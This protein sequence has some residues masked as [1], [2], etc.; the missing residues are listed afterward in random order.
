MTARDGQKQHGSQAPA[1][2]AERHVTGILESVAR[3][4]TLPGA[5]A[6]G[7]RYGSGHIHATYAVDVR[8]NGT[9]ERFIF[10]RI[11][12]HIFKDIPALME[13][14]AR[15]LEHVGRTRPAGAS[16]R[17]ER[18]LSLVPTRDG[19]L[20][21]RDASGAPWRVYTFVDRA[22]T[23][24]VARDAGMAREAAR[25]YGAFQRRLADLPPPRLHETIPGFHDTPARLAALETA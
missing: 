8:A 5:F 21:M 18:V 19:R 1:A 11:N 2:E 22:S 20:W 13:N 6:G 23:Y 12:E 14:I 15:V 3:E 7:T 9:P 10:Q 17:D 4:F 16:A 25:A 24:D